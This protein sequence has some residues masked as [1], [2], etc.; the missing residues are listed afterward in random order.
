MRSFASIALFAA[1]AS[2]GSVR[3]DSDNSTIECVDG[4]YMII[5]RGTGEDAGPG[6]TGRVARRIAEQVK[7]STILGLDYPASF[8]GEVGDNNYFESV[9]KGYEAM[10]EA[11]EE[12]SDAC[13]DSLMA[14]FGYS[15]G[16][17]ITSD[18]LCGGSGGWFNRDSPPVNLEIVR[19]NSKCIPWKTQ[20]LQQGWLEGRAN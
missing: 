13:P 10:Q 15:Q 17:Q 6:E 16:A 4:L 11:I 7:N 19:Q 1:A 2:V 3:A 9:E 18:A 8:N 12:Y 5:A 14:V 20:T